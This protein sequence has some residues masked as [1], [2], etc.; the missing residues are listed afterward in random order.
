MLSTGRLVDDLRKLDVRPGDT[1]MLL[2]SLRAIGPIEG[3]TAALLDALEHAVGPGGTLLMILGAE[4]EHDWVNER[5]EAEREAL[6]TGTKPFDP[7]TAPVFGEVGYFAEVFRNTPGTRVTNNPSGRFGARGRFARQLLRDAPWD[8]YYGP[9]SPLDRLCKC[10]GKILRL[11]ANPDTTT[12]LHYAE[13]LADVPRKRRVRRHYMCR[14]ADGPILRSVEC[15]D[16]SDGIVPWDG[17]DYFALILRDYLSLGGAKRGM[18]GQAQTELIEAKDL[19]AFGAQ[20][21]SENLSC[22]HT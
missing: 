21:M 8:D 15:L 6:L 4:I 16:D 13:Y 1:L 7:A 10:G 3:G 9:D 14:S 22:R 17:E 19:V 20:W 2:V 18:V 5:P 12:A 11:G